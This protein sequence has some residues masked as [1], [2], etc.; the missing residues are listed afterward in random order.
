M[1]AAMGLM[2][3]MPPKQTETALSAL[4][5]LLPHHSSDL[6][7]QVDQPLLVLCDVD[8]GKE[9]ILCEYNRDADSY[10]YA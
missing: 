4:L 7:S 1:E 10:R 5:S 3:R 2:R 9:F 6:L 8:C